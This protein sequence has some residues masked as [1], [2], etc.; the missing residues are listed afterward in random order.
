[1]DH[2]VEIIRQPVLVLGQRAE[3]FHRPLEIA[4]FA[5]DVSIF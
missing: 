3:A 5:R 1:M 4:D 2:F